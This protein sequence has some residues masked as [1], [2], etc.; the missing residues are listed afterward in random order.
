[1]N[2]PLDSDWQD[3]VIFPT[4]PKRIR[5]REE[6]LDLSLVSCGARAVLCADKDKLVAPGDEYAGMHIDDRGNVIVWTRKR[7]CVLQRLNGME[8]YL[9]LPRHPFNEQRVPAE[10]CCITHAWKDFVIFPEDPK[11]INSTEERL[12]LSLA[13]CGAQVIRRDQIVQP[14][15]ELEAMGII[16]GSVMIW[17]RETVVDLRRLFGAEKLLVVPRHPPKE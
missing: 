17:T 2:N 11:R 16:F 8:T 10:K 5:T 6:R 3:F 13:S 7:V 4:D 9:L 12:D 14:G 15:D 1:M